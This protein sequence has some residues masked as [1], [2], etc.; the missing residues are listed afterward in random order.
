MDG[1]ALTRTIRRTRGWEN[2]PVIIMTS[3]GEEHARQAGLEAGC[4][5]YL[6]KDDF[7]Q[8]ELVSTVRRLLG[9]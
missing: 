8:D 5:A 2:V 1:F 9:E 7:D 4:S 3:R 6:L